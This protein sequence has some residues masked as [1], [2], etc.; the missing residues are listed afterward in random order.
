MHEILRAIVG[1]HRDEQGV[2]VAQLACGHRQHIRHEPPQSRPWVETEAGRLAHLGAEL[3]C[4]NCRMPALPEGAILYRQTGEFD[5]RTMPQGLRS[6]HA[7]KAGTWARIVVL[8]GRLLYTI[9]REPS[10]ALLLSPDLAGIVEPEVPHH[11]EPRGP[12]RFKIE[13]HRAGSSPQGSPKP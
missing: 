8:E 2:W 5:E 1:C 10:A 13:F 12:V 4:P 7:L 6:Q 9:E 3:P 11:V